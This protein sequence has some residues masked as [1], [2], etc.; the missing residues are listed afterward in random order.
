[1]HNQYSETTAYT[2]YL[3]VAFIIRKC[4]IVELSPQTVFLA[5]EFRGEAS[6][7]EESVEEPLKGTYWCPLH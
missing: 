1:M 4:L 7:K 6:I 2:S 5:F 3:I